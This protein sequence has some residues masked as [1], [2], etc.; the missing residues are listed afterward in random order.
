[1]EITR[2]LAA[3]IA[4]S[5][6]TSIPPSVIHEA[7]RSLLNWVGCAAGGSQHEAT[8]KTLRVISPLSSASAATVVGHTQR[9]DVA[10]AALI[11]SMSSYVLDFDDAHNGE[12]IVLH[13]S[14]PAVAAALAMGEYLRSP[15][16]EVL[17][18]LLLG[19]EIE[20][21]VGNAVFE[22][23]SVGWFPTSTVG[24]LG[25]AVAAGRLLRLNEQQLTW[26]IGIAASQ[27]AGMRATHGTMTKSF[28][29]GRAASNG[30]LAALLA[31]EDVTSAGNVLEAPGT[32]F[33]DLMGSS[34]RLSTAVAELGTT[35]Q[36]LRNTYKP[37]AC[38]IGLHAAIDCCMRL[39]TMHA[40]PVEAIERLELRVFPRT[41]KSAAN[42]EPA[43]G[44]QAKVSLAHAAAVAL[45]RGSG[46]ENEFSDRAACDPVVAGLRRRV[47]AI[48]D[49]QVGNH[50][51][52]ATLTLADGRQFEQHVASAVGS[53][54]CPM[55]DREL[56]AKAS[57]LACGVLD[58]SRVRKMIDNCWALDSLDTIA[59]LH[60]AL[61][62]SP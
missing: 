54:D 6:A 26:A 51:A 45:T 11:N 17:L 15:G 58:D 28:S 36:I 35:F 41:A 27:A 62:P 25:A 31:A 57:M 52:Y 20:C 13:P 38:A 53:I 29:P 1:M 61:I 60:D 37:F 23:D 5:S 22:S 4:N 19:M 30:V 39:R 9:L 7:K 34:Q 12:K 44:L 40:I 10:N 18:A 49:P 55:T 3:Y 56:E 14:G 48:G 24:S 42:T 32:G 43:T 50:E 33:A 21:R 2:I 16:S 8:R 59:P 47:S 46:G